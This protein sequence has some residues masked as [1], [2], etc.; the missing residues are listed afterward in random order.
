MGLTNLQFVV[1]CDTVNSPGCTAS[2]YSPIIRFAL[3]RMRIERRLNSLSKG[4]ARLYTDR[5]LRLVRLC[6]AVRP[7]ERTTEEAE[8]QQPARGK[9]QVNYNNPVSLRVSSAPS[10]PFP[11][12]V[13]TSLFL[14]PLFRLLGPTILVDGSSGSTAGRRQSP[15][16]GLHSGNLTGFREFEFLSII[17]ITIDAEWLIGR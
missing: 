3:F 7:V 12:P 11:P 4:W 15:R 5:G 16:L 1:Q 10:P 14:H 8:G 6:W 17:F 2:R 13:P 9:S